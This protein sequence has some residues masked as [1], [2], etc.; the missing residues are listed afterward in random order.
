MEALFPLR[1]S[2]ILQSMSWPELEYSYSLHLKEIVNR[3]GLAKRDNA[4]GFVDSDVIS[5]ILEV[6]RFF[7]EL[8]YSNRPKDFQRGI[9]PDAVGPF[10]SEI[11]SKET[12][13]KF[14]LD[15]LHRRCQ[16]H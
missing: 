6:G 10:V 5:I 11:W 16:N 9:H 7:T 4:I 8:D 15:E 3:C 14:T 12:R 13:E 2:H 1:T